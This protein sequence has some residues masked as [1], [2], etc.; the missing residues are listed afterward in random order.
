MLTADLAQSWYR[1]GKTGP[2]Y[3][4]T[5]DEGYLRDA[6][7][8]ISIFDA[9]EGRERAELAA[10]LDEYVGTGTDY[11]IMRGLIKLLM[12]RCEF[13]TATRVEPFEIRRAL[14]LKARE[15][16]PL[17]ADEGA[18]EQ[19]LKSVALELDCAPEDLLAGLYADLP[20]KQRLVEFESLSAAELLDLYNLAQAQALLYRCVE[21]RLLVGPQAPDD[22][23]K[24]FGAIKAYRL[25]HTVKGSA[26]TGYEIRL[27]GP[28]SM[29]HRSQKYGI[30]MAVFLPALL[31]CT[32]WRMRAEITL[33]PGGRIGA[34]SAHFEMDSNQHQLRS[35][36]VP[37]APLENR[38][39]ETLLEKWA[40]Y[41]SA[42]TLERSSEVIDLGE[43]AF[44]P[45]FVIRHADGAEV[46]LEILGFWTPR[47]LQERLREFEHYGRKNFLIAASDE[48]RGSR[49]PLTRI[50]PHVI[51]F[52]KNLEPVAVE[53]AIEKLLTAEP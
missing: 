16:H 15:F 44:V 5:A 49:D 46:Y 21:M 26:A 22:Y 19:A 17:G 8:L 28:V 2:R 23:R 11:K 3:I 7:A 13:E 50:P 40:D 53:L 32:N 36:Y 33:K 34:T 4:E 37:A 29:F 41:E 14:F 52:K 9:H 18:R 42:W 31:L 27:D 25:I 12:D 24:L 1:K 39:Q 43:S 38:A 6:E 45:D 10:A 30:Q 20:D 51:I 47:H 48:L 35:S